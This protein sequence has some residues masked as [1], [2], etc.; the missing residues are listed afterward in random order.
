LQDRELAIGFGVRQ[1][2][3]HLD[4][5]VTTTVRTAVGICADNIASRARHVPATGCLSRRGSCQGSWYGEGGYQP[6]SNGEF[7]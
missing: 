4:P 5:V 1:R 2:S 3:G 6:S 7:V